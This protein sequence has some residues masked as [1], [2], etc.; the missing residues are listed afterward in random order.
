MDINQTWCGDHF[1]MYTYIKSL[2]CIPETDIM[3]GHKY[4][5]KNI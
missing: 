3:S 4:M 1:T 2:D 5:T